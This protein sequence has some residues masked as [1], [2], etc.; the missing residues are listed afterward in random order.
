MGNNRPPTR[1]WFQLFT[2]TSTTALAA[3]IVVAVLRGLAAVTSAMV[4]QSVLAGLNDGALFLSFGLIGVVVAWHQPRNPMG[5][6]L[7]GVAFRPGR[8]SSS[9]SAWRC[10]CSRT[11]GRHHRDGGR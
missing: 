9:W 6:V 2:P 11:D 8:L 10:C 7:L 3:G 4:H 5:W 1:R